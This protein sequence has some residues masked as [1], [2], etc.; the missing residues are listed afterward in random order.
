MCRALAEA[1]TLG[2]TKATKTKEAFNKKDLEWTLI[3]E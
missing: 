3:L 1:V 2:G